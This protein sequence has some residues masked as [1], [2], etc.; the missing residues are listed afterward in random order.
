MIPRLI[1]R[2]NRRQ[3]TISRPR[4]RRA[5]LLLA[6]RRLLVVATVL[7]TLSVSL[8]APDTALG[9]SPVPV[10]VL[11]HTPPV[12]TIGSEV[13]VTGLIRRS[14]HAAPTGLRVGLFVNG[15]FLVSSHADVGGNLSFRI[16]GTVTVKAGTY[17][18]Q[19]RFDGSKTLAPAHASVRMK[20]KPATVTVTTVPVV[21]GVPIS[22]GDQ[23]VL[24]DKDGIATFAIKQVGAVA[25]GAHVELIS[26]PAIRV[27]FIRWGDQVYELNRQISVRGNAAFVLGLRTAYL[28]DVRFVDQGG[29]TIDPS[30]IS[31]ARF[32]SSTG[33]ELILTNFGQTWWEASTAV[34]RTGGLQPASTLW[35]LAEVEMAGS[36]AVNQGQQAF[37]PTINGTWTVDLLLFDLV[38]RT[39]DALTGGSLPGTA[40]LVFPDSRSEFSPIGADGSAT[41]VGLPRGSY[42]VKLKTDGIAPVTP[43]ALSRTQDATI[44][45]I[46]NFDIGIGL[47]LVL[48]T[49]LV[50]VWIGRRRHLQWLSRASAVPMGLAR[51]LPTN[52]MPGLVRRKLPAATSALASVPA[53]VAT[54]S[55]GRGPAA[56]GF[57]WL[58]VT[59]L[60]RSIASLVGGTVRLVIS[61]SRRSADGGSSGSRDRGKVGATGRRSA[62]SASSTADSTVSWPPSNNLGGGQSDVRPVIAPITIRT[63]RAVL[64]RLTPDGEPVGARSDPSAELEGPTHLCRTCHRNV[65]DSDLFCR[66][67]GRRQE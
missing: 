51:R 22:I 27:S 33:G 37:N 48:A 34:S 17:D 57:S 61:A 3:P 4:W 12:A 64:P 20:V 39:N 31:R 8:F 16:G 50:L 44:R 66:S 30:K 42:I 62:G 40:E 36:N 67:C 15:R 38:V 10:T 41:F 7:L 58:L 5:G 53:D 45:V 23:T 28:A 2:G 49:F 46:S 63:S 47:G 32:T 19:A 59:N 11:F 35:R 55:R 56:L 13:I 60:I 26:D 52:S 21:Q 65:L 14:D 43:I 29:A 25:L 9:A 18:L 54:I 1:G 24:T 6:A